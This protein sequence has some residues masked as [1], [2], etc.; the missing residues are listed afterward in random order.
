MIIFR[1]VPSNNYIVAAAAHGIAALAAGYGIHVV[2]R[3]D[4]YVRD[5]RRAIGE[6]VLAES[7]SCDPYSGPTRLCGFPRGKA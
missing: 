2:V 7:C 3:G 6:Q 1:S 4:H 5:G